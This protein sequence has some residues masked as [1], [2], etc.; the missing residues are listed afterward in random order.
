MRLQQ[1]INADVLPAE[2]VGNLG[3]LELVTKFGA[4]FEIDLNDVVQ[5]TIHSRVPQAVR[6]VR[7]A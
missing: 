7:A 2:D 6:P 4:P 3:V 5:V 1:I